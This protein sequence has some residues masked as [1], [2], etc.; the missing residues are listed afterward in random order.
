MVD[1]STRKSASQAEHQVGLCQE[2]DH[3]KRRRGRDRDHGGEQ[4]LKTG[5]QR[6]GAG[7]DLIFQAI[8]EE[9]NW[10]MILFFKTLLFLSEIDFSGAKPGRRCKRLYWADQQTSELDF[11]AKKGL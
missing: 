2:E 4:Q 6:V 1:F 3:A 10:L 5:R 9:K 7:V 8:F 11:I